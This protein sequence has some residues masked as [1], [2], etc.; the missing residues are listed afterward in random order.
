MM[1]ANDPL[2]LLV[3]LLGLIPFLVCAYLASAWRGAADGQAMIALIAYGAVI[4]SF[5]GG[6]H[7]GFALAEPPASLA[8][9]APVPSR[10]DPAHKPRI[11]LG[12]VP[13]LVGWVALVVG[14][15]G[16]APVIALC[17]LIAGFLAANIG[18]HSGYRR[19][20]VPAR[21]LWLRWVLTTVVV[22]LLVTTVVLRLSGARIIL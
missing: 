10:Q 4:L 16:S 11:G 15:L 19:G 12:V 7:W 14:V 3:G 6:V 9:L 1:R 17:I 13:S 18:E 21:Y 22:A 2:V 8:G 20:W 5:L